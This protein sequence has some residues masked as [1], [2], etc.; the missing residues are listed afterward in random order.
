MSYSATLF[1]RSRAGDDQR[2][3]IYLSPRGGFGQYLRRHGTF[4]L[5]RDRLTLKETERI[6]A[7]LLEALRLYGLVEIVA[8]AS[9]DQPV[10]GYQLQAAQLRWLAGDGDRAFHDPIRV[11]QAPPDGG[12]T[13]PFFV[14]L[15]RSIV[16]GGQGIEAREHTAQVRPEERE[17]REREFRAGKLP[18]L[19]CSPTMEL[20][21]DIASL[22]VVNLRNVPPTPA[23]YAQRSGRAG[24][25]GQ[26]ALVYTFCSTLEQPRPVLLPPARA[27]GLRTGRAAT[28]RP[29]QRGPRARACA[30]DL[31]E[32]D[33]APDWAAR[34]RRSSRSR[35]MTRSLDLPSARSAIQIENARARER[36]KTRAQAVLASVV[37]EL[38]RRRLVDRR[39]A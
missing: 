28:A 23:N 18:L 34:S 24:R 32:R 36:A 4:P 10:P 3:D 8:P 1:P 38:E 2:N 16:D 39:L 21:V 27:D 20:G 13:N 37:S 7:G 19:F 31:A 17:E 9:A 15:Y 22:N 26:P 5:H 29:R 12:R 14:D 25:S 11:P 30:R 33:R 6:I 35:A